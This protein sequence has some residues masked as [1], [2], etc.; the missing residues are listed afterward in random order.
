M[1]KIPKP[2]PRSNNSPS[3]VHL[4]LGATVLRVLSNK[5]EQTYLRRFRNILGE[6]RFDHHVQNGADRAV[7]YAAPTLSCCL[8]EVFGDTRVIEPKTFCV[9]VI[10]FNRELTLLDIRGSAAMRLGCVHAI[11]GIPD[12]SITWE[13]SRHWYEFFPE[14][15]GLLYTSAHNGEDAIVLYERCEQAMIPFE[16][17]GLGDPDWEADIQATVLDNNMRIDGSSRFNL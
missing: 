17:S 11:S 3:Y 4:P 2:Q 16:V 15:D 12:R 7:L 14:I 9:A 8:V 13:W 10:T 1:V 5:D 6:C